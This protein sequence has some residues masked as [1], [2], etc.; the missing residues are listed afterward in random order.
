MIPAKVE[1][2]E[3]KPVMV[4]GKTKKSRLGEQMMYMEF[5][6]E[7]KHKIPFDQLPPSTPGNRG[8]DAAGF[9]F[10]TGRC[11]STLVAQ[12]L[13]KLG[14]TVVLSE[15]DAFSNLLRRVPES[16][17]DLIQNLRQLMQVYC[18]RLDHQGTKLII[19]FSSWAV[20]H[21]RLLQRAFPGVP[22]VFLYRDPLEVL[23]SVE[24]G[25][26]GWLDRNFTLDRLK[27]LDP[28]E[29]DYR[30][31]GYQYSL[32]GTAD[33]FGTRSDLELYARV[34]SGIGTVLS[35]PGE[36]VIPVSYSSLPESVS[37]VIAP[38]FGLAPTDDEVASMERVSRLN[39]HDDTGTRVFVPDAERKRLTAS[40]EARHFADELVRE[41]LLKIP[42]IDPSEV[43]K[44]TPVR[45][46]KPD[47]KPEEAQA[48][49]VK[50][51]TKKTKPI[52]VKW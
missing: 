22:S 32:A 36:E 25:K 18:E 44:K 45:S 28:R 17:E 26:P 29:R 39:V 20:L 23:A 41:A 47:V 35:K 27:R 6:P 40:A 4:F 50:S 13:R 31:A 38:H 2:Q 11:G 34:L 7:V 30:V 14:D 19:K 52:V 16:E 3:N 51:K 21:V 15:P 48:L 49:S 33:Y 12:M 10:H 5:E 37:S 9:V 1:F 24:S 42:G 46:G 43:S 8:L